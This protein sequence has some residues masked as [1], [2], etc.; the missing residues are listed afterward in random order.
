MNARPFLKV[1]SAESIVT[2]LRQEYQAWREIIRAADAG[3]MLVHTPVSQEEYE[4][5]TNEL[6]QRLKHRPDAW[7]L[8]Q[9]VVKDA[10]LFGFWEKYREVYEVHPAVTRALNGTRMDTK[11]PGQ[12]FSQLRHINP[13]FVFG[14]GLPVHTADGA[15]G[16][17]RA[18]LLTG[19][20][21][22]SEEEKGGAAMDTNDSYANGLRA[23]MYTDLL[24]PDGRQVVDMDIATF[25]IRFD[26]DYTLQQLVDVTVD[27][28][29][30]WDRDSGQASYDRQRSYLTQLM[31]C[32]VEHIT[33]AISTGFEVEERTRSEQPPKARAV[34]GAKTA[35]ASKIR[36]VGFR[37]GA[38]I[39]ALYRRREQ[40]LA[41]GLGT[42][43]SMAPH[44]RSAHWH[45]YMT[46]PGRTVP[47]VKWLPPIPINFSADDG[48][49]VTLHPVKPVR[50]V[51]G[52]GRI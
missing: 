39:E 1:V 49:T 28:D 3:F 46:G 30:E 5:R 6:Y 47:V 23:I 40:A 51:G 31:T 44:M 43:R 42:G 2:H 29:F 11:I 36:R 33:Y 35:K 16:R 26:R 50:K 38:S 48:E 32:A 25:M 27:R 13:M 4:R 12:L 22:R 10:T 52:G 15:D 45:T 17:L 34:K 18:M 24:S 37:E 14:E 21:K 7:R 8:I 20:R 9:T 19:A 41:A